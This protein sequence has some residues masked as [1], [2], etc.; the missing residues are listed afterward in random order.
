MCK[1]DEYNMNTYVNHMKMPNNDSWI[2]ELVAKVLFPTLNKGKPWADSLHHRHGDS[3]G[4]RT[5]WEQ[6]GRGSRMEK[7]DR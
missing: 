5:T 6:V 1:I 2:N 7:A 4:R 3:A